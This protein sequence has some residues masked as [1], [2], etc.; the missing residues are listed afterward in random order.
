MIGD[1]SLEIRRQLFHLV[2]G[3]AIAFLSYF[4]LITEKTLALILVLGIILSYL[5]TRKKLP[6]ISWF[7][8]NF[9]RKFSLF[10]GEGAFFLVLGSFLA[11]LLF[12]KN[13][14]LASIM[15]LAV[16]D[17]LATI[18][19]LTFGSTKFFKKSLE[20]SLGGFIPAFFAA[21]FFV[22][23]KQAFLG[24]LVAMLLEAQEFRVKNLKLDD[25]ILIP[26]GASLVM[27][28]LW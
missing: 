6:I 11:L 23:Y 28:L 18:F 26:L 15:I 21:L 13:I 25:N 19:G 14:A 17:S 2:T 9:D 5:S 24:T 4:S 20:G 22:N 10:P 3:V 16:G 8:K 12:Q 1:K 7:L 27:T